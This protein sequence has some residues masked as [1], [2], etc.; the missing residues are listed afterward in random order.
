M[1]VTTCT[2]LRTLSPP[3]QTIQA[4]WSDCLKSSKV[5]NKTTK[6]V[7]YPKIQS[8]AFSYRLL[9]IE[10]CR[11]VQRHLWSKAHVCEGREEPCSTHSLMLKI[12]YIYIFDKIKNRIH[13]EWSMCGV[14]FRWKFAK[15]ST[16]E[17]INRNRCKLEQ[18]PS[19]IYLI[20]VFNGI[21]NCLFI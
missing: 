3:T 20:L 15:V 18:R 2:L 14:R 21:I 19:V 5:S 11:N 7:T 13:M 4:R 16:S 12:I 1:R 6:P 9:C 17:P 10:T 8:H